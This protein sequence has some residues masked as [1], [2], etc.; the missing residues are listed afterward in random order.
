M[1]T[2]SRPPI[3]AP[4]LL[5]PDPNETAEEFTARVM[6][7]LRAEGGEKSP[8][9]VEADAAAEKDDSTPGT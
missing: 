4:F 9:P 5:K 8:S 3:R 6:Y 7:Y 2:A 1:A